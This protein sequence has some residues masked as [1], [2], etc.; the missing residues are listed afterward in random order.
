M[1]RPNHRTTTYHHRNKYLETP[2]QAPPLVY[3]GEAYT[4]Y[5]RVERDYN[6]L[7]P[8]SLKRRTILFIAKYRGGKAQ[9]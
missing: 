5:L 9:V 6:V 2:D 3:G 7:L 1:R 8:L 4:Y